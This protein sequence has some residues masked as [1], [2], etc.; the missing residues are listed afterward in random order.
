MTLWLGGPDRRTENST[1]TH[2]VT[3]S[4]GL[5]ALELHKHA[6]TPLPRTFSSHYPIIAQSLAKAKEIHSSCSIMLNTLYGNAVC[7]KLLRLY[8]AL[9]LHSKIQ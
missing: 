5:G 6:H 2:T 4:L 7:A 9:L 3:L 1:P 8:I